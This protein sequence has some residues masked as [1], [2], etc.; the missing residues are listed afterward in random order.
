MVADNGAEFPATRV[1]FYQCP[2]CDERF[3]EVLTA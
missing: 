2:D 3:R 1:E